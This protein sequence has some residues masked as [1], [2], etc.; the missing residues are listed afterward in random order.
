MVILHHN[1]LFLYKEREDRCRRKIMTIKGLKRKKKRR[2]R[3]AA[4]SIK[5]ESGVTTVHWPK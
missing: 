1:L 4:K 2:R 3:N 5:R